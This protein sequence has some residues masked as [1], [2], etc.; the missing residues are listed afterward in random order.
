MPIIMISDDPDNNNPGATRADFGG[1]VTDEAFDQAATIYTALALRAFTRIGL[2]PNA[3]DALTEKTMP[4][5]P[6]ALLALDWAGAGANR[7][8]G[9]RLVAALYLTRKIDLASQGLHVA[10]EQDQ[11]VSWVECD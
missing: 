2:Q 5:V 10:D 9:R 1:D 4:N 6:D 8:L 11:M 3:F 7:D